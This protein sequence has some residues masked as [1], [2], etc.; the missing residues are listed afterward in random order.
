MKRIVMLTAVALFGA[1][2]GSVF[3]D[4]PG[5][6]I[7]SGVVPNPGT[8]Q[9]ELDN[10]TPNGAYNVFDFPNFCAGCHGGG[11]DQNVSHYGNWA[12]TNMANSGRDPFFRA[13]NLIVNADAYYATGGLNGAGNLCWRCHSPNGWYS[14]RLDVTKGGRI[15]G[16]TIQQSLLASTDM[17]GISCDFCHR[18]TDNVTQKRADLPQNDP[19]WNLLAGALDWPHAGNPYPEGPL[20]GDPYGDTTF[21]FNNGRYYQADLPG[22]SLLF[23]SDIP[24]SGTYTGQT[25]GV[26]PPNYT[27]P[28]APVPAGMPQFNILG[29]EIVYQAD[30]RSAQQFAVSVAAP[31]DAAGQPWLDEQ[32]IS[33]RHATH[34]GGAIQ[35]GYTSNAK[36]RYV[37]T[38]EM[39]GSCHDLTVPT[40]NSG[41]P[42]QRTYTEWK[43]SDFGPAGPSFTICQDCHMGE[44]AHEYR[45]AQVGTYK[46]DPEK[47]GYYPWAK[48]RPLSVVHRFS[49]ANRDLPK[50]LKLLNPDVD[51]EVTGKATGTDTRTTTG[52]L[53]NRDAAWDRHARYGEL[54]L[55]DAARVQVLSG[56]TLVSGTTYAVTARVTNLTGHALPSGYPD[57]RRAFMTLVVKDAAGNVLYENGVWDAATAEVKATTASAGPAHRAHTATVTDSDGTVRFYEKKTGAPNGDGTYRITE[58]LLNPVIMFDNRLRPSGF[59]VNVYNGINGAAGGGVRTVNYSGTET[60]ATWFNEP[61]LYV[62]PAT[63]LGQNFEDV[64]YQF[65]LPAGQVPASAKASFWYQSHTRDFLE[66]LKDRNN[67]ES[68]KDLTGD[69]SFPSRPTTL[70]GPKPQGTPSIL[71]ANYPYDPNYLGDNIGITGMTDLNGQPLMNNWGSLAY[72]GW[73]LTN[74]GEPCL[75]DS[76]DT[77]VAAAPNAPSGV[78]ATV[79]DPFTARVDWAADPTAD[80]YIVYTRFGTT[81]VD[82]VFGPTTTWERVAVVRNA[83]TFTLD[84]LKAGKSYGFQ[85]LAFNGKGESAPSVPAEITTPVALPAAPG[86][87]AIAATTA[88]SVSLSWSDNAS[89]E[90]GFIIERQEVPAGTSVKKPGFVQ[91]A[92]VATPDLSSYTDTTVQAGRIYNYRVAAYN[93]GG[94]SL[95]NDNGP[96]Q[97]VAMLKA[98]TNLTS[99]LTSRNSVA[100]AWKD[101]SDTETGFVVERLNG[102]TWSRIATTA[103][104]VSR[105]TVTGLAPNTTYTFRVKAVNSL[106]SS[107]YSSQYSVK[108]KP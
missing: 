30:G 73:L 62:D 42:E 47:A 51:M 10:I 108:T 85:V 104:N 67:E 97:A 63:S 101:N 34:M 23:F 48:E 69:P 84:A 20:P 77:A 93:A 24:T 1:Y 89:D 91:I 68:T 53:S 44:A 54:K 74:K 46:A 49:P 82:P 29:Q 9:Q 92:R 105:Y 52:V 33:P 99:V 60:A 65:T 90:L 14:A 66:Y 2:V 15:D 40:L 38:A 31:L 45:D 35:S 39:C 57:G 55:R 36:Y 32:S 13:N 11:I 37:V 75:I 56:P 81:T 79:L 18:M 102:G 103:A 87:L 98:P 50:I 64:T 3:A 78:T 70:G 25:Y 16:T 61:T 107:V 22:N 58:S 8:Q 6:P 100:L 96:K 4:V 106:T 80:G 17:Q 59:D 76:D 72:A 41:M 19:V 43:Y 7:P 95:Y 94:N 88:T 5:R 27:G 83:T 28:K 21:M 86:Q 26:Y 12:G 71:S